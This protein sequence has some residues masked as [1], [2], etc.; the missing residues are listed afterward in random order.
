LGSTILLF[1]SLQVA[2]SHQLRVGEQHEYRNPAEAALKATPGDTILIAPGTYTG[3]D[4]FLKLGGTGE[5]PVTIKAETEG[6][7]IFLGGCTAFQFTAPSYLILDGIVFTQQ[8]C[9]GV[10]IDDGG[11]SQTPAHHIVIQNCVWNGMN[12]TG[13]N[14]ELKLSGLQNFVIRKCRFM[15][16]SKGGS[17]IDMVGCHQGVIEENYFEHGGSNC[18]QIKGG[19]SDI[20]IQRNRFTDGGER[21]INIGGSTG[22]PFFRPA[23]TKY[24]AS[25]ITV[26]SN[27]F[28]GGIVPVAFVGS[29]NC[30]VINNTII[31]PQKW[32][33]R[34]LQENTA[35]GMELC[36]K[37]RFRNNLIVVTSAVQ[38][39]INVGPKTVPESFD[40][41]N[42]LWFSAET[43]LRNDFQVPGHETGRIV[44]ADPLFADENYRLK[45]SSPAIGKGF[46]VH[47]PAND[48]F[49]K[50]FNTNRAIGAV[51]Y[52][53]N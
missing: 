3:Q 41:S 9:N 34:I 51:E 18:I 22:Q 45:S 26:C 28:V 53:G 27:I 5:A 29:I 37:N 30:E 33:V 49:N 46:A 47:H 40:F 2:S 20:I 31:R 32:V 11:K 16:G 35:A 52:E 42:N 7:T 25:A 10:N 4:F 21:A 13:N 12:A 43:G 38:I 36:S 39:A 17:M 8:T 15:N 50:P 19:S 24:E 44:N 23:G 14:D 6:K 48:Y 1:F